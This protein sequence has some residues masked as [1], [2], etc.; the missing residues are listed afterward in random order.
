[1]EE[2]E[3]LSLETRKKIYDSITRHP[4]MH[5]REISRHTGYSVAL[6]KYHVQYLEKHGLL[7]VAREGG[8]NRYFASAAPSSLTQSDKKA[9]ALLRQEIPLRIVL[10]LLKNERAKHKDILA[11][12]PVSASTLSFHLNKLLE[13]EV[14]GVERAGEKKGYYLTNPQNIVRLLVT[15][16]P[17]FDRM[18]DAFTDL[19]LDIYR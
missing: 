4:G 18:A 14:L 12:V 17:L 7:T 10:H 11:A 15:F 5:M 19:W 8:Y 1:L 3:I 6:V 13:G 2:D 16:K 9:L